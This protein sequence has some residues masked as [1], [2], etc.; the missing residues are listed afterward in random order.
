MNDITKR[1]FSMP[2]FT[3]RLYILD[4]KTPVPCNDIMEWSQARQKGAD[5]DHGEP[6]RVGLDR[7]GEYEI[8]TVFLGIDMRPGSFAG[9]GETPI[10]FETMMFTPDRD[11]AG[12]GRSATYEIAEARHRAVVERVRMVIQA[13][14]RIEDM[15]DDE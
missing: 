1:G 6:W 3:R 5:P 14:R 4:G 15:T 11:V 2:S 9:H 10:L 8:S 12:M 7:V 13:G